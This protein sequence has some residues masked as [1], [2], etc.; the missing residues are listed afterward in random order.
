MIIGKD[1][2][3]GNIVANVS[4]AT[5]W[6]SQ[7]YTEGQGVIY[8]NKVYTCIL[9]TVNNEEPTNITY[10]QHGLRIPVSQTVIDNT[11]IG[12]LI[13]LDN[14]T[15]NDDVERIIK[16]DTVNNY[17]YVETNPTN[18]YSAASPTY[19]R[20]NVYTIRNYEIGNPWEHEIGAS[21]IGGCYIPANVLIT[22]EY[23]NKSVT[24]DKVLIGRVE[25]L[26]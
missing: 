13:K 12:Y 8:N 2:I 9:D 10:W 20:Q 17:I 19:V 18:S 26:Y 1:T 24:T 23:V 3:I 7:N 15:N 14:F 22:I 6:S 11:S 16:I 25:Y 4:P 21:K 5:I